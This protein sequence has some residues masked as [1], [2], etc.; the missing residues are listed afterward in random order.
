MI[1]KKLKLIMSKKKVNKKNRYFNTLLVIG[2]LIS[3]L[4]VLGISYNLNQNQDIRSRAEDDDPNFCQN[5]CRPDAKR[6][7]FNDTSPHPDDPIINDPCCQEIA[8]TGDPLACPWPQRGYCT[9][10]QCAAI[11]EGVNRQRCGGPRHSW[12]NLCNEK[13]PGSSG[14]SPSP[15]PTVY[16]PP[17]TST[18][19]PTV[20]TPPTVTTVVL[21]TSIPSPIPTQWIYPTIIPSP[22]L[23]LFPT[24]IPVN[25]PTSYVLPTVPVPTLTPTPTP[26]KFSFPN[27][28]PPKE[29]V[30]NF[31]EDVRKSFLRFLLTILP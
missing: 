6:C 26:V 16:I 5:H 21:P 15:L 31:I 9:D 13:C 29:K 12:C 19:I 10:G 23:F 8:R 28:L 22:T 24:N 20:F 17:P 4:T 7:D 18:P 14:I 25:Y 11:P 2:V 27:I 3:G 1:M 30:D